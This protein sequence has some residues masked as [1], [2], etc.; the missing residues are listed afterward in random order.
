MGGMITSQDR[1]FF[2]L[3]Y[4]LSSLLFC[5]LLPSSLFPLPSSLC[6]RSTV[7][8]ISGVA[9]KRNRELLDGRWDKHDTK[10]AANTGQFAERS[11]KDL[12]L[13]PT[14][15]RQGSGDLPLP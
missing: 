12:F 5:L 13:P 15:D 1:A 7:V 3:F 9:A 6:S 8:L 11:H 4:L 14:T 2:A 10:D